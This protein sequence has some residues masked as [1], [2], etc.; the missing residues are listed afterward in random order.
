MYNYNFIPVN[1]ENH[2]SIRPID[3]G[4]SRWD[5]T[6]ITQ[7]ILRE[8]QTQM[9]KDGDVYYVTLD[10]GT[11][12]VSSCIKGMDTRV[13]LCGVKMTQKRTPKGIQGE[14]HFTT[15]NRGR[16]PLTWY[17]VDE[18]GVPSPEDILY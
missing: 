11:V 2:I 8:I 16:G 14:I 17:W 10:N 13:V 7:D 3:F 5:V 18:Y 15:P 12:L 9:P 6:Y 1:T 4:F